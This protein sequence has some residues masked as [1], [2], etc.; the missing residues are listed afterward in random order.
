MRAQQKC[1]IAHTQFG[2]GVKSQWAR[3]HKLGS[4]QST[5]QLD[6]GKVFVGDEKAGSTVP[7]WV[8]NNAFSWAQV[9]ARDGVRPTATELRSR[10]LFVLIAKRHRWRGGIAPSSIELTSIKLGG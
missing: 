2:I 5:L 1:T 6:M 7:P 10:P 8:Q 9:L 4:S 3:H